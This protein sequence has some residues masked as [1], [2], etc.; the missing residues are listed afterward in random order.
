MRLQ[1]VT[2]TASHKKVQKANIQIEP[3]EPVLSEIHCLAVL[4][5]GKLNIAVR[6]SDE[7]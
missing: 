6:R 4:L 3:F 2:D 7:G 1:K 5:S